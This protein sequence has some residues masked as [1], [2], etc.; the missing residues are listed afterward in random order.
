MSTE[1][2]NEFTREEMKKMCHGLLRSENGTEIV[3]QAVELFGAKAVLKTTFQSDS[4]DITKENVDFV[5]SECQKL[6]KSI[7]DRLER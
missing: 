2:A 3:K 4:S 5:K 7:M 6:H 1:T